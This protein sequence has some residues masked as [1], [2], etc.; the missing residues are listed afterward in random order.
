MHK[1]LQF[2]IEANKYVFTIPMADLVESAS[3]PFHCN[4][5]NFQMA[6]DTM[7]NPWPAKV[8]IPYCLE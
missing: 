2:H 8:N 3:H 1:L 6:R 5:Y 4:W 7:K